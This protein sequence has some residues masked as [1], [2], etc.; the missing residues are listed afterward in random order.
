MHYSFPRTSLMNV[1]E[2]LLLL[3]FQG[4]T[5][6]YSTEMGLGWIHNHDGPAASQTAAL[7]KFIFI[8]RDFAKIYGPSKKLQKKYTSCAV[9][10]GVRDIT[11]WVAALGAA[12]SGPWHQGPNALGRDVRS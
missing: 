9:A 2:I 8:F 3:F 10:H 6:K 1:H 7:K 11:L 12:R 5:W 4:G